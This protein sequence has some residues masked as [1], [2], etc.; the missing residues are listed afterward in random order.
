MSSALFDLGTHSVAPETERTFLEAQ[1]RVATLEF[2]ISL[3][4]MLAG[5]IL[6]AKLFPYLVSKF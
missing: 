2:V 6:E 3:F 4:G 5:T 1:R